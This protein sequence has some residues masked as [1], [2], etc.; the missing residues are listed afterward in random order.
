MDD[1]SKVG[2]QEELIADLTIELKKEPAFDEDI[3]RS[4]VVGA[5]REVKRRRNYAATSYDAKRIEE[6][7]YNYY[8]VIRDV[9]LYDYN[10]VGAEGQK[11][12]NENSTSR[13]WVD[14]EDLFK[15][16]YAFVGTP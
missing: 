8:T 7:L 13:T 1:A 16:V 10:T 4:K 5:I 15:T 14:K 2:L 9:V 3:L 11:S 12:H 6:D